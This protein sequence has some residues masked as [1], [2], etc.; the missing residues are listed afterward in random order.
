MRKIIVIVVF[1]LAFYTVKAQVG[2]YRNDFSIGANAGYVLSNVDFLPRVTQGLHGGLTGGLSARY[3]CEK[4]FNT[5]CSIYGELNYV[6]AGWKESILD[7]KDNPVINEETGLAEQ[8]ERTINYIQVPVFAHLA[9]GKEH[10]GMQFFFQA[11]PQIGF[12][13]GDRVSKNFEIENRNRVDRANNV[14]QQDTMDIQH[15]FDYG[16]A[17]G[18]GI[19]YSH[20]RI[21]HFLL[22]A[23]YYYGLANIYKD[24]KRDFFAKSS[25]GNIVIKLTY[26]FDVSRTKRSKR[27]HSN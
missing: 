21:G 22:E 27:N 24:S 6:Q 20:P 5:I 9:W 19:E 25:L 18:A 2:E 23:R 15:T 26:L 8:Y 4:Y 7:Q 16:I 17:A 12:L 3:V 13:L 1:A 11:G 14:V 10:K